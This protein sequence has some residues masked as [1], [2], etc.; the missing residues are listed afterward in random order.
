MQTCLLLTGLTLWLSTPGAR[1]YSDWN[2]DS[3][4]YAFDRDNLELNVNGSRGNVNLY[5]PVPKL[6]THLDM[7]E[8]TLKR[9]NLLTCH[10]GVVAIYHRTM[11]MIHCSNF[12]HDSDP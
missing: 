12:E 4:W 3:D 7:E 1:A 11:N 6:T 10:L 9:G 2:H 5:M 8:Q